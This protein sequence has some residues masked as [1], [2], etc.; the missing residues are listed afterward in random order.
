MFQP[1]ICPDFRALCFYWSNLLIRDLDVLYSLLLP[2]FLNI[3]ETVVSGFGRFSCWRVLT[4]HISL[5]VR[6][7]RFF[8]CVLSVRIFVCIWAVCF[9]LSVRTAVDI[10][11]WVQTVVHIFRVLFVRGFNNVCVWVS[12]WIHISVLYT[13]I[14]FTNVQLKKKR[15]MWNFFFFLLLNAFSLCF[16]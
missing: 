8:F 5:C 9:S 11:F 16:W 1:I 2:I 3:S 4:V 10:S 12:D 6:A 14:H 15:I 13:F 7:V